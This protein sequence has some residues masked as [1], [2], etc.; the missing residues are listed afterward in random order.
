M[1]QMVREFE[2]RF[3]FDELSIAVVRMMMQTC[4]DEEKQRK[5][6]EGKKHVASIS[7]SNLLNIKSQTT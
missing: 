3:P 7:V 6:S 4:L 5:A 2:N 1:K